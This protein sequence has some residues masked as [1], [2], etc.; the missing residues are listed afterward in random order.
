MFHPFPRTAFQG[1]NQHCKIRPN[2]KIRDL[3]RAE[4]GGLEET[5]VW[6]KEQ[7]HKDPGK[8]AHGSRSILF[9]R[10]R[11]VIG[12]QLRIIR[13]TYSSTKYMVSPVKQCFQTSRP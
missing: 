8:A 7:R 11:G 9:H 2:Q 5:Q 4:P 10:S 6:E 13:V 3:Q 1:E 12:A